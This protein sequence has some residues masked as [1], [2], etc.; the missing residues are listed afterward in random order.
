MRKQIGKLLLIGM[1]CG[2]GSG[3][4]F[5][6]EMGVVSL[7][8]VIKYLAFGKFEIGKGYVIFFLKQYFPYL[9]FQAMW[10][11][12]LYQRFC[13]GSIY[14]FSRMERRGSWY[15]KE[16]EKLFF[17]VGIFFLTYWSATAAVIGMKYGM[18]FET[19]NIWLGIFYFA[20]QAMWLYTMTLLTNIIS[21]SWGSS[22]G[23]LIVASVVF[24]SLSYFVL[25]ED[26]LDFTTQEN[27]LLKSI[28]LKINPLSHIV[29]KWHSCGIE[30]VNMQLRALEI[31]FS[32][33]NSVFLLTLGAILST[34]FG[35]RVIEK[36]E[37]IVLNR[38]TG[39]TL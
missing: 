11:T 30:A 34:R 33:G 29:L 15:R 23:Y 18:T 35:K 21:I 19:S 25:F 12:Y 8:E 39:G 24:I 6:S 2:I 4:T 16:A 31:D 9:M 26:V 3:I 13:T 17:M 36:Q 38:E 14:Y 22:S 27:M 32:I 1:L 7:N 37:F 20:T 5:F 28:L 10:G